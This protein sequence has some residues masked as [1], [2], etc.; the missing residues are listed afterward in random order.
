MFTHAFLCWRRVERTH[1]SCLWWAP[2]LV[3]VLAL[4]LSTRGWHALPGSKDSKPTRTNERGA[5]MKT[6]NAGTENGAWFSRPEVMS[7]G[8]AFKL[9]VI[10][11]NSSENRI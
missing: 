3:L 5:Q 9:D 4:A 1:R 2:V 10:Q 8:A 6:I 7:D 11:K